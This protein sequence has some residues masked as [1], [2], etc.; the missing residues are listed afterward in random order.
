MA[1]SDTPS[2]SGLTGTLDLSDPRVIQQLS[3][4]YKNTTKECLK[5]ATEELNNK[6]EELELNVVN[7]DIRLETVEYKVDAIE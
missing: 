3:S 7:Q 2:G 4:S 1:N 5:E 6:F